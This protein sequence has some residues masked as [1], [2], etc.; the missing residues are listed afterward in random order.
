MRYVILLLLL[1]LGA[2]GLRAQ[3][4]LSYEAI[5]DAYYRSYQYEKVQDYEN[6]IRA[7]MPVYKAY[8][9]GYTINLRLGWLYYLSGRYANALEHYGK[10]VQTAPMAVEPRLGYMLPL[11]AQGRYAEVEQVA[12]HVLNTDYYN[13][14]GNLRLA[15]A[16]RMQQKWELA[17]AVTRKMLTLYPTD[18]SFL[19]E[20][21]LIRDALGARAEARAIFQDV[22]ILDPENET[23][24]A[25]LQE[26]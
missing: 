12:Y 1:F 13:Y 21:G 10:A 24:R 14:Y 4:S 26:D 11:L 22:L 6:A 17:E 16:L 20:L 7:L 3:D 25:Y 18:I 19:T 15:F 9:E 8:P 2:S 23:A 5:R